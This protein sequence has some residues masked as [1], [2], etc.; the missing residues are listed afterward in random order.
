MIDIHNH[1]IPAIDDGP[2]TMEQS[3]ELL[4]QAEANGIQRLVCTPH[5]HPGRYDND[6]TT[7]KPA[8][9]ELAKQAREAGKNHETLR[10]SWP[11][12]L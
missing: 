7:I 2:D 4:W 12:G 9:D 5:M 11:Q 10:S 3:L 8:F 1:V 6:I